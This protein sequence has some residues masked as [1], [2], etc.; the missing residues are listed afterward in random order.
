MSG[1]PNNLPAARDEAVVVLVVGEEQAARH[2]IRVSSRLGL[3]PNL[4]QESP[5]LAA[6]RELHQSAA[7]AGFHS[8]LELIEQAEHGSEDL[9]RRDSRV[10]FRS[11][12][13]ERPQSAA[14]ERLAQPT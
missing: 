7:L 11:A 5:R 1:R 9:E 14:R 8:P 6:V 12:R 10:V 4:D 2:P 13:V 3:Y